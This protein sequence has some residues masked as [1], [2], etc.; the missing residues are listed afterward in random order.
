[1]ERGVI[2]RHRKSIKVFE[3]VWELI[4]VSVLGEQADSFLVINFVRYIEAELTF[5]WLIKTFLKGQAVRIDSVAI[6]LGEYK[7]ESDKALEFLGE[8]DSLRE[9]EDWEKGLVDFIFLRVLF[10]EN[11]FEGLLKEALHLIDEELLRL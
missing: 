6:F 9:A 8:V 2:L 1:M 10:E 11:W 4:S 5:Y 3:A 7:V